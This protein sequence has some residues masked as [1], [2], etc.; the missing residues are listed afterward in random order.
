VCA[1][2]SFELRTEPEAMVVTKGATKE[3]GTYLYF[4]VSDW[5]AF[6]ADADFELEL[7][8]R[9]DG[10][11]AIGIEYDSRDASGALHGAYTQAAPIQRAGTGVWRTATA[12]LRH[13]RFANR[14]NGASDLRLCVWQSD[15]AVRAV[16]VLPRVH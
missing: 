6:D 13:A 8:F 5:F 12:S 2:G 15:L 7:E 16:R 9:D 14:E 4:Q 11:G 3:K 1:D 10:R